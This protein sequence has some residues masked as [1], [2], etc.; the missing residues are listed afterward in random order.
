METDPL[1]ISPF[2][3]KDMLVAHARD[4][5]GPD[6]TLLDASRGGPNWQLRS[7]Q[8][9]W[10]VLGLYADYCYGG[11]NDVPTVR[12]LA[13]DPPTD[14]VAHF[15]RFADAIRDLR[16][17]LY[18]GVEYLEN[19]WDYLH[20]EVFPD[21]WV[22]EAI[23]SFTVAMTGGYYPS[24]ATLDFLPPIA[25]RFLAKTFGAELGPDQFDLFLGRGAT[26]TFGA[27]VACMARNEL[28]KPGD[29]VALVWPW[30]EPMKNLFESQ[31]G[32]EVIPI[33]RHREDMWEADEAGLDALED[34]ELRLLVIVSPG[35][36]VDVTL[37]EELLARIEQAVEKNPDLVILCDYVYANF[38]E[39][40]YDNALKRVPGNVIPF[41][42]PSKDLGLVGAR[43][44]AAWI[45][46]ALPL[47]RRLQKMPRARAA[48][49]DAPYVS[50]SPNR[51]PGFYDRLVM[52]SS[53]V[54]FAHMAGLPTP[55]QVLLAL[56]LL[57]PLATPDS[58]GQ[59]FKWVR[60]ELRGRMEALYDGLGMERESCTSSCRSNYC[61]LLPLDEIAANQGPRCAEAFAS[62][63]L[64]R[65]LEH[66]A[67]S[68]G[69]I[70]MPGT[71]FGG[72]ER[73]AR[74]CLTSLNRPAYRQVG[75]NIAEAIGDYTFPTQ[76]PHCR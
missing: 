62:V 1:G 8:C 30:Y 45:P 37:D 4:V 34:P 64:W 6:A 21:R 41:Y 47:G 48:K 29:K 16:E 32:C 5:L 72:E 52:D 56:S 61:A 70:I 57:F 67:H 42:A 23:G 33:R 26:G 11:P 40:G 2:S 22:G 10:E 69:T 49:V 74:V 46:T 25:S 7:V 14:H 24:P 63:P 18:M 76:C 3:A 53:Q 35:N 65:F 27:V 39:P 38:V 50:R 54:S 20:L 17:S 66:L 51:R 43:L 68:R 75:R 59:Y 71:A 31:Y 9:A 55:S 36:P 13:S 44:G 15:Q 12:I 60:T 58:A 19:V 28:L 73:S